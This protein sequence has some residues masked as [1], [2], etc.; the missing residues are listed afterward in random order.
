[1]E[2]FNGFGVQEDGKL[3]K[4]PLLC[5]LQ[6]HVEGVNLLGERSLVI[7]FMLS[8]WGLWTGLV[9]WYGQTD[10]VWLGYRVLFSTLRFLTGFQDGCVAPVL[11]LVPRILSVA[12]LE[13]HR[14]QKVCI[15]EWIFNIHISHQVTELLKFL[16]VWTQCTHIL[17]N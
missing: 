9:S 4:Q 17:L 16:Y 8:P 11:S 12:Q 6:Y 14:A 1:M 2:Q 13:R 15:C 3:W 5:T 7:V 10:C